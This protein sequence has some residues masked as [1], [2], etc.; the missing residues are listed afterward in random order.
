MMALI[1]PGDEVLIPAPY[2]TSYLGIS[3]L[4]GATPTLLKMRPEDDYCL[5]A[6]RKN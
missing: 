5:Q 1:N 2:W 3:Q 4:V 6:S